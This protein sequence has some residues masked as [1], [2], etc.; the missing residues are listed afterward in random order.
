MAARR[1]DPYQTLGVRPGVSDNELRTT[2]RRLVQLHH[3]D[4][5]GGSVASARRFEEVQEAYAQIRQLRDGAAHTRPT[6]PRPSQTAPRPSQTAPR[7]RQPPPR[8]R[9]APLRPNAD[10]ATD[11]RLA[12][13]ERE[14]REAHSA[15]ELAREAAR[16]AAAESTR[17]PSD[18]ELGYVTT[19]DSFSKILADAR[20]QASERL[21]EA[22]EPVVK[23]VADLLDE[24]ASKLTGE[25]PPRS[26][27]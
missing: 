26:G 8:T 25:A 20:S 6:P 23:R 9:Q 15:R 4:Q 18:E 14:I 3:P 11:S 22:R 12:D 2:Y 24:L 19:D 21:S 17:R 27:E 1:L 16:E 10:P 13:L 5:N 7:A